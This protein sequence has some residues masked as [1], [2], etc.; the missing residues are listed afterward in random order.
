MF[1]TFGHEIL[2]FARAVDIVRDNDFREIR[3]LVKEYLAENFGASKV[4]FL[5]ETLIQG[6]PGLAPQWDES[7][8]YGAYPL[9]RNGQLYGQ[10]SLAFQTGDPL[11]I[12][13]KEEAVLAESTEYIDLWS[14]HT[15][16]PRFVRFERPSDDRSGSSLRKDTTKMLI[17]VPIE[18]RGH[19]MGVLYCES[20]DVYAP[21]EAAKQEFHA[22]AGSLGL[23]HTLKRQADELRQNTRDAMNDLRRAAAEPV[24]FRTTKPKLYLAYGKD[25][26]PEI[27]ALIQEDLEQYKEQIHTSDWGREHPP[28]DITGWITT[29]II[30]AK[31]LVC[32]L[33]DRIDDHGSISFRDN[34]NVIFETGMF[35]ALR[36][37]TDITAREWLPIREGPPEDAPFDFR[38]M[39]MVVV[40]RDGEG[41]LQVDRFRADL[42]RSIRE[43]LADAVAET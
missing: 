23:L 5:R 15:D 39:R 35:H 14:K 11:W 1:R 7:D 16:V 20:D 8:A 9:V 38:P 26:D 41:R 29:E 6:Q 33:S 3:D 36:E 22:I 21:N 4:E 28:G 40:P 43:L 25:R 2:H 17:S 27:L 37:S 32:Y 18:L 24:E 19:L 31:Y 42:G 12:I 34:P 30:S 13:G 10:N